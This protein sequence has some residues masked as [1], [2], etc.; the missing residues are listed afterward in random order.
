MTTKSGNGRRG[1]VRNRATAAPRSE[2]GRRAA[3]GRRLVGLA[4]A[5]DYADVSTRTLRRYIAHGRLTGYRVGPRLIKVDL[6]ELD[7][8][9][10]P[11][12]TARGHGA[13]GRSLARE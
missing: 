4:V 13:A 12:P 7:A 5:A 1:Q 9:A 3:H 2:T 10:R 8:M 11:I 6:N